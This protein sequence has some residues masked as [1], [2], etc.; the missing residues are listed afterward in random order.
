MYI[1]V[2]NYL[3]VWAENWAQTADYW[4][5]EPNAQENGYKCFGSDKIYVVLKALL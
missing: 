1:K 4:K 3:K 2:Y 5:I